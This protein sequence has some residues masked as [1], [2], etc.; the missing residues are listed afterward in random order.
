MSIDDFFSKFIVPRRLLREFIW[1]PVTQVT[2]GFHLLPPLAAIVLFLLLI[3][4]GQIRE[5][6]LSYVEGFDDLPLVHIVCAVLAF[7]LLSAALSIFHYALSPMQAEILFQGSAEPYTG[8]NLSR[9]QQGLAFALSSVPWIGLIV[10]L[11]VASAGIGAITENLKN[12]GA[13]FPSLAPDIHA[14]VTAMARLQER[15][16][17]ARIVVALIGIT[18]GLALHMCNRSRYRKCWWAAILLIIGLV[19]AAVGFAPLLVGEGAVTF[20]RGLGPLG[21]LALS[22]LFFFCI[23]AAVAY[24]SKQASAHGPAF[25]A[26]TLVVLAVGVGAFF[27]VPTATLAKWVFFVCTAFVGFAFF[28]RLD[29]ALTAL[30]FLIAVIAACNIERERFLAEPMKISSH[31]LEQKA[32]TDRIKDWLQK[33]PDRASWHSTIEGSR[34]PVF[35]IAVEGGGIYAAAAASGFLGRLQD[36]CTNFAQHVFAI[37]GVSGGALGATSFQ[38]LAN[39]LPQQTAAAP[40]RA[41][42][43]GQQALLGQLEKIMQTDHFSPVVASILPDFIGM[44]WDRVE[45]LE[46]SFLKTLEDTADAGT[47]KPL[48]SDFKKHWTESSTAPALVL[49]ATWAET[50]YRVA[51]APF[52]LEGNSSFFGFYDPDMLGGADEKVDLIKAAAVSARF[53][54]ILP[55]YAVLRAEENASEQQRWNFVDGGYADPS[56]AATALQIYRALD[57]LREK[58]LDFDLILVVLTNAAHRQNFKEVSGTA[59]RDVIAPIDAVL[60][61]RKVLA[62]QAIARLNA[63]FS[64]RS[65]GRLKFIQLQDEVFNLPLGWRISRATYDIVSLLVG[66][67]D[68]CIE[69]NHLKDPAEILRENGCR[70]DEIERALAAPAQ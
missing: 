10:G 25:P 44:N 5:I 48:R 17:P 11:S 49:N 27:E 62:G 66:R 28:L 6:Y 1:W 12:M 14:T 22:F 42:S 35:V 43:D 16:W 20:Y 7:S 2:A 64:T 40:C 18:V 19:L 56:G 36:R 33:R 55:P 15:I 69:D 41:P 8:S 63:Y 4:F 9:L 50:G 53:P 29:G 68:L 47:A 37:S 13:P 61:A 34:Y 31:P 32:V 24:C 67:A 60:K 59:F 57:E 52:K 3:R 46:K 30:G 45:G 23:L 39:A 70:I 38:V 58:S 51:F 21:V 54:G 26:V 65:P